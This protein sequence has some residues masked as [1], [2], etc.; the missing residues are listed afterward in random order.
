MRALISGAG[1]GGLTAAIALRN[2]GLEVSVFERTEEL[3][4]A[5]AGLE[6]WSNATRA[7]ESL[8]FTDTLREIG[9]PV[10][11]GRILSPKGKV[12]S[13]VSLGRTAETL[14]LAVHRAEL[15]SIFLGELGEGT[16]NLGSECVGF[17][18]DDAGVTAYLRD[19]GE[20]R[21]D[22]LVGADGLNSTVRRRL[23]G[24][25]G[26]RYAGYTA[27]RGVSRFEHE[28]VGPGIGFESWGRGLRF[29]CN[30]LGGGR[31]YWF[32][33]KNAPEGEDNGL[34][35]DRPA[36]LEMFRG[37]HEPI[38]ALIQ[39]TPEEDVRRDDIYD[40]PPIKSWGEGRV[41][42]LGDAAHPMTPNLAQGACQAIE[43][44]V[45]LA[46]CLNGAGSME[47]A[48]KLYEK[49]R[50]GRA[51]MFVRRSRLLGRVG[52]MENPLACRIRDSLVGRVPGRVQS[53]QLQRLLA[54][55]L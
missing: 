18:Q 5:G 37:W 54:Y 39:A 44:A 8:G 9:A 28:L 55:E 31:V 2:I 6:L 45:V 42:L 4:E 36:L 20:E 52:Q 38:P 7:L 25:S 21:G 22:L 48:L 13:K 10:K 51:A 43:D 33:S 1:I 29:G 14:F 26:P 12:I 11:E 3:R 34:K 30:N 16:L 27:W 32:V 23:F 15:L 47:D 35:D 17:G 49:R 41:T 40:R 46:K 50:V 24:G 19:G 53:R